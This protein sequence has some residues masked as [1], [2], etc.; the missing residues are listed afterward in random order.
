[1]F[2]ILIGLALCV[3]GVMMSVLLFFLIS[4][5]P[6]EGHLTLEKTRPTPSEGSFWLNRA[7]AD[8]TD[9]GPIEGRLADIEEHVRKETRAAK[10]FLMGPTSD[11]L[12]APPESPLNP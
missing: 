10:A 11:S 5:R 4:D 9:A 2:L 12:H 3:F 7:E 1:M 6:Q 8:R